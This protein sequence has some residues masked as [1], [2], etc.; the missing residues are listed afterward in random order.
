MVKQP[1]LVDSQLNFSQPTVAS[2]ALADPAV[3]ISLIHPD[4]MDTK[5]AK[6][7]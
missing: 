6:G 7:D 1:P 4:S 5:A 3:Q 2:A